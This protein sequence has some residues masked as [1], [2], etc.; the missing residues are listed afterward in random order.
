MLNEQESRNN[1]FLNVAIHLNMGS[2]VEMDRKGIDER[3]REAQ[4]REN[5]NLNYFQKAR[6]KAFKI[7][8]EFNLD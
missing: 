5:V 8:Y 1:D 4:Q 7:S 3:I 2:E 6:M